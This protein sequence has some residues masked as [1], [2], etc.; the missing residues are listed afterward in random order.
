MSYNPCKLNL[1]DFFDFL[2]DKYLYTSNILLIFINNKQHKQFIIVI[3]QKYEILFLDK[4]SNPHSA[5]QT[6]C[7][8]QHFARLTGT[9]AAVRKIVLELLA[10]A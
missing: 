4:F 3:Y 6:V 9:V 2:T 7:A 1:L 8:L 5:L 10:G